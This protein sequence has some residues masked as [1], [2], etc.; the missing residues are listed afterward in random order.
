MQMFDL[1]GTGTITKTEF[2]KAVEMMHTFASSKK[3]SKP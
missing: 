2:L 1:D 3:E